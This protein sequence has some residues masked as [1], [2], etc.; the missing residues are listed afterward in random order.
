MFY[1]LDAV[2]K[3]AHFVSE[4]SPTIYICSRRN[5]YIA[6]KV[7]NTFLFWDIMM[8]HSEDR[9]LQIKLTKLQIEH[10]YVASFFIGMLA[11]EVSTLFALETIYFS[12]YGNLEASH[13]RTA[14][15]IMIFVMIPMVFVTYL[16][17][18]AKAEKLDEQIKELRKRYVW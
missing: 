15:A 13:V 9:E 7:E 1:I 17:F 10:Q 6:K 5:F 14:T 4:N 8:S 16:Y 2:L 3:R 11:L 12:L 18:R